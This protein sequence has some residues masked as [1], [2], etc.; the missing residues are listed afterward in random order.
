[1]EMYL[2]TIDELSGRLGDM[3]TIIRHETSIGK[4]VSDNLKIVSELLALDTEIGNIIRTL[5]HKTISA[6]KLRNIMHQLKSKEFNDRLVSAIDIVNSSWASDLREML[7]GIS[8][9]QYRL[10]IYLYIG[11]S[12]ASIMELLEK[13]SPAALYTSKSRSKSMLKESGDIRAAKY[14]RD[15]KFFERE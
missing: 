3:N 8:D 1:M 9:S 11:L 15:L 14:L 5:G 7:P 2:R 6:E 12:S 10:A 13:A 4:N